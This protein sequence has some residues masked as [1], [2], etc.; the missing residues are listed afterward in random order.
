VKSTDF[1]HHCPHC[2]VAHEAATG[3]GDAHGKR[4]DDGAISICIQCGE[5]SIFYEGGTKLRKPDSAESIGIYAQHGKL[6]RLAKRHIRG[7]LQ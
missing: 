7:E 1:D 5:P 2:F 3:V 6:L 4:P